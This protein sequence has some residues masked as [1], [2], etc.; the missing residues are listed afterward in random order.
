MLLNC[1]VAKALESP[2]DCKE[3][4]AVNSKGNQ[5]WI[6][7]GMTDADA[8][9]PILWPPGKRNWLIRKDSDAVKIEVTRRRGWQ[10]VRWLDGIHWLHGLEIEQAPGVGD[11]QG[12]LAC[13]SPWISKS[14]TRL[15]D[16]TELTRL[17][18]VNIML[19]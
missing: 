16:W 18:Y 12:S 4:K 6:F 17:C 5:S 10:R 9:A 1:G 15:S 7:I 13:S 8:E 14:W 3:I 19:P 2:L 11:G